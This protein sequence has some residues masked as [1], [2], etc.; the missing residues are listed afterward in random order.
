[1]F[2]EAGDDAE[3][4]EMAREEVKA[5]E[6]AITEREEQLKVLLLPKDPLDDKDVMLEIRAGTGGDEANIW[7][8]D[9]QE[10]Y[11]KYAKTLG[12]SVQTMEESDSTCILQVIYYQ[13]LV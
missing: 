10:V 6:A 2:Q 3:M 8:K 4:R 12:W 9:L 7:A 13:T 5:L 11:S 1:M